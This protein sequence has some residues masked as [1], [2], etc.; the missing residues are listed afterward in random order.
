MANLVQSLLEL[1]PIEGRHREAGEDLDPLLK[2]L[3]SSSK[4]EPLKS[5]RALGSCRIRHAPVRCNRLSRPIRARLASGVVTDG[6]HKIKGRRPGRRKGIPTLTMQAC[7][8]Q[9]HVPQE[10]ERYGM[11]CAFRVAARAETPKA[12]PTPMIDQALSQNAPRRLCHAEK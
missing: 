7:G 1:G 9:P 12:A 8:R 10:L 6:E 5:L 3:K 11:H 4:S 2:S